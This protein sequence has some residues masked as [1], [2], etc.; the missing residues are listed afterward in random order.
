MRKGFDERYRAEKDPIVKIRMVAIRMYKTPKADGKRYTLQEVGDALGMSTAWVSKQVKRY[1]SEGING[2]YDRPR[3]GAPRGIDHAVV[4]KILSNWK[5]GKLTGKKIAQ[6]YK[7][8]TGQ[9]ISRS[10]AREL[11]RKYGYSSKKPRKMYDNS[12][13]PSSV[14]RWQG[15]NVG[16]IKGL[17]ENGYTLAVGDEASFFT[18]QPG[19]ASYY[20]PLGKAAAT[21]SN[22]SKGKVTAAGLVTEAG[23]NGE[24]SRRIHVFGKN[25]NSKMFVELCMKA[26]MIFGL[27]VLVVDKASWHQSKAIQKL[28]EEIEGALVII[29]LPTSS[30]Y[31]NIKEADWRQARM[32]EYLC[33]HFNSAKELRR[34]LVTVLNTR[35]ARRRGVLKWLQRSPYKNNERSFKELST[36]IADN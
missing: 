33:Y 29:L 23:K 35:L 5:T 21:V 12:A 31:L 11:A 16:N 6:E 9:T 19:N 18:D 20:A 2:L 28:V 22:G 4:R 26:L 17:M 25:P 15:L 14:G 7:E 24:R 36:Y 13:S 1:D 32:D 10:Y 8:I 27:V 34:A 3:S 30:A